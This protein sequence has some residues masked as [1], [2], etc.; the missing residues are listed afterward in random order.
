MMSLESGML[1][2][3]DGAETRY[4][5]DSSTTASMV[6]TGLLPDAAN[7]EQRWNA[8]FLAAFHTLRV[9]RTSAW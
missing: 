5:Y 6:T 1:L 2:R 8:V 4:R 3:T 9:F 7:I